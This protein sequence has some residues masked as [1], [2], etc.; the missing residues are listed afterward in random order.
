MDKL[1]LFVVGECSPN[2]DEWSEFGGWSL[3]LAERAE[4]AI[5]IVGELG[6]GPATEVDTSKPTMLS[7]LPLCSRF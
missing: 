3:V 6:H 7:H 2:P 1:R 5:E 4:Q